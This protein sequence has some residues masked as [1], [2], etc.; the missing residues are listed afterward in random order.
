MWNVSGIQ[1]EDQFCDLMFNAHALCL[2]AYFVRKVPLTKRPL[3]SIYVR[4]ISS[5]TSDY[6]NLWRAP[7]DGATTAEPPISSPSSPH[8]FFGVFEKA[9][10]N[11][12]SSNEDWDWGGLWRADLATWKVEQIV[13]PKALN[14]KFGERVW[15][16][17]LLSAPSATEVVCKLALSSGYVVGTLNVESLAFQTI[18]VLEHTFF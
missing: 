8:I 13:T 12:W 5:S 16:S 2:V 18:A 7:D 11:A 9:E 17:A 3:G 10:P 14:R 6:I 15:I 1:V 4:H